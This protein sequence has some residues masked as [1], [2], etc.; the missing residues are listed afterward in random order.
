MHINFSDH[1]L[2][3]QKQLENPQA[4][5]DENILIDLV[6]ALRPSDPH[7]HHLRRHHN[8]CDHD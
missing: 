7:D 4:V 8:G 5:I 2:K 1:F 6:N 3:I